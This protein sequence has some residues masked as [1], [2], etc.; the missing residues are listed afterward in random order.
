MHSV[1]E[2]LLPVHWNIREIVIEILGVQN[3]YSCS[4]SKIALTQDFIV[5]TSLVVGSNPHKFKVILADFRH[6]N[7]DHSNER[8]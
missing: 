4:G 7:S 1:S 2:V 6:R 8:F 5:Y 3:V